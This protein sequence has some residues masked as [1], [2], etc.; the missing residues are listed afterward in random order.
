MVLP[1][2]RPATISLTIFTFV[3]T[4]NSFIWPLVVTNERSRYTLPVALSLL[5]TNFE[6]NHGLVMAGSTIT[7][8]VPF[9]LYCFLQKQFVAGIALG[10]VKE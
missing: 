3:A 4:W 5:A 6:K 2:V 9:I 7:F 8:L 10:G 1:L